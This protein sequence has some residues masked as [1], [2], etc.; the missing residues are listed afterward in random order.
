MDAIE[1]IKTRL[2]VREFR[3]ET[4]P[5]SVKTAILEAARLTQSG[6]NTQHWRFILVQN[7]KNIE[8]MANDTTTGKWVSGANFAIV[9]CTDP[10][11]GY[12]MI[13]AGRAVQDMQLAAWDHGVASGVFRSINTP[14]FRRHFGIPE[15]LDPTIAVGFGYPRKRILGRK[16][17]KPLSEIAYSERY[18]NKLEISEQQM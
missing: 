15:E 16:N 3:R 2:D 7:P 1:A 9:V 17:R 6:S 11:K 12:H 8:V 10:S 5:A 14:E 13:D 4:V 18:G